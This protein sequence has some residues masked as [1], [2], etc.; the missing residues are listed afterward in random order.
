M[1]AKFYYKRKLKAYKAALNVE[2]HFLNEKEMK[3]LVVAMEC[4]D[5]TELRRIEKEIKPLLRR[6]PKVSYLIFLN[7]KKIDEFS[8]IA[9]SQD[10]LLFKE[11]LVRRYTPKAD[12]VKAI[13]DLKADVFVN[14]NRES[15]LVIDFL[16]EISNAR[17]RIGFNEKVA[18]T[19][20]QIGVKEEKGHTA[21]FK[22]MLHFM[23]Q[24]N[25]KVA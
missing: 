11:D 4:D 3:H 21:F 17:M 23:G 12:V 6:V 10:I 13:N 9:T 25:M 1:F 22:K 15:S 7:M 19:E 5:V 20:L 8:Y 14:L 18:I 2:R 16:T 24:I